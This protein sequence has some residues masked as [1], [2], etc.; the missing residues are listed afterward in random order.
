MTLNAKACFASIC[1]GMSILGSSK[2]PWCL[3]NTWCYYKHM[4]M[5]LYRNFE[6]SKSIKSTPQ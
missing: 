4:T 6:H 1:Q 3:K 5:Q 2:Y